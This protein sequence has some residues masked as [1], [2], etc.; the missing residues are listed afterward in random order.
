MAGSEYIRASSS[1]RFAS[2]S[3]SISSMSKVLL[4]DCPTTSFI[5]WSPSR[6]SLTKKR[7]PQEALSNG[8]RALVSYPSVHV[9]HPS[10][11]L[12]TRWLGIKL[13]EET[14]R[15]RSK[16]RREVRIRAE[17]LRR[18]SRG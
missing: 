4:F 2:K 1:P 10:V 17:K 13:V 8:R 6:A 11:L 16:Y 18:E 3:D 7:L 9:G 12:C 5:A 14:L 15:N